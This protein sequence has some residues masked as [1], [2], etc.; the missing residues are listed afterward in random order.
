MMLVSTCVLSA[1]AQLSMT[2]TE[3]LAVANLMLESTAYG[4]DRMNPRWDPD[5]R[6]KLPTSL[7]PRIQAP[8]AKALLKSKTSN[9]P[10]LVPPLR[11]HGPTWLWRSPSVHSLHSVLDAG[12]PNHPDIYG[13][14]R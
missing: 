13:N 4:K 14:P 10:E 8:P 12:P 2:D 3:G 9:I 11:F 6:Y 7:P 1:R 5:A